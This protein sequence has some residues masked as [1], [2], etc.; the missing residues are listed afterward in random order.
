M[1]LIVLILVLPFFFAIERDNVKEQ[2]AIRELIEISDYA[3]STLANLY[4]L[5]N[6]SHSQELTLTKD[7]IYLPLT[8]QGS[9]YTLSINSI[10]GE[11]ASKVTTVLNEK[12]S[13][14]G[15]SWLVPGLKVINSSSI[16]ITG[17]TVTAGCYRNGDNFYVWIGEKN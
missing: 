11:N 12:S 8:V 9:F 10:D 5:S 3:S 13:V 7:L 2:M 15:D 17:R 4:F 16:E 14:I 1:G 6:S